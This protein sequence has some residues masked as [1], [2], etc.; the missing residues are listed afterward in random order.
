MISPEEME[1]LTWIDPIREKIERNIKQGFQYSPHKKT[2][3]KDV[4]T[5]KKSYVVNTFKHWKETCASDKFD[6]IVQA[7]ARF[8]AVPRSH[9]SPARGLELS[10]KSASKPKLD[11]N[12]FLASLQKKSLAYGRGIFESVPLVEGNSKSQALASPYR[13]L[14]DL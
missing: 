5:K 4:E 13:A 7:P 2:E 10:K 3:A 8:G 11:E 9:A 1:D 14:K 6:D 12:P